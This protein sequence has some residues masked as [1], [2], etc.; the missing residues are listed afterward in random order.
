MNIL[1]GEN[2]K[3]QQVINIKITDSIWR[4]SLKEGHIVLHFNKL[5]TKKKKSE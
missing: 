1:H 3:Q 4:Q 2:Y 5:I